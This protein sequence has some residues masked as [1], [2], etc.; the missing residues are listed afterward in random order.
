M[1][2]VIVPNN[3][4]VLKTNHVASAGKVLGQHLSAK[5]GVSMGDVMS[6]A[7]GDTTANQKIGV[8]A[9]RA[10]VAKE[11]APIVADAVTTIIEG[12]TA[13]AQMQEKVLIEA[14]KGSTEILRAQ[15]AVGLAQKQ[16]I[17]T[18]QEI[19]H[20][21]KIATRQEA[22]RHSHAM[23][24]ASLRS[25]VSG[26]MTNVRQTQ[27]TTQTINIVPNAQVDEDL[28]HERAE[29]KKWLQSGRQHEVAR[30]PHAN[31]QNAPFT[32]GLHTVL[33]K[34]GLTV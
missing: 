23:T 1:A 4:G 34:L 10:A 29:A 24:I 6:A 7:F 19:A 33:S 9:E 16:A 22:Q 11:F 3:N 20:S 28:K 17:N 15:A 25:Y 8:A 31:Y 21:R 12:T 5:F 13:I 27:E 32:V 2:S 18:S 14:G 30:L 26:H